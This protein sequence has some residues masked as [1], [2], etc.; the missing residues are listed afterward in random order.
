M[1]VAGTHE[2]AAPPDRVYALLQDP[3]VLAKCIPGCEGLDRVADND[4]AM[5]MKMGIGSVSGRFDGK[6]QITDTVPPQSFRMLVQGQGG[7]G[8][9]KGDGV[10]ALA[11]RNGGSSVTFNGEVHVGG[12]IANV[13]QR[14]IETTA[15]MIIRRFFE[16]LDGEATV[17]AAG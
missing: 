7:I 16:K 5:R 10:I 11:A 2:V 3:T 12:A 9:M 1:K 8:F 6:V 15:K 14:L 4:Y 13:G 17:P